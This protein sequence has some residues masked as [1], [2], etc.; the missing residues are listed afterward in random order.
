[1]FRKCLVASLIVLG[2]SSAFAADCSVDVEGNDQ[3]R[4]NTESIT[5]DKSCKEFTVNLSHT[6]TMPKAVMGHNWVLTTAADQAAVIS[7]GMSAGVD[8]DYVKADDS[9]VLAHTKVIGG[10]EKDSITFDTSKLT[11]GEAYT[12]FCSFPGHAALMKGTLTVK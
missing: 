9:R 1:M 7:E 8:K 5:V 10:G 3:M 4:F 11:A 2:S 12:F 6:G